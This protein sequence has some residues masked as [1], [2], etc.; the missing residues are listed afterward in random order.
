VNYH[1]IS[2][3]IVSLLQCGVTSFEILLLSPCLEVLSLTIIATLTPD[4]LPIVPV[5]TPGFAIGGT[6]LLASGAVYTLIGIKNK[7]LHIFISAA[8]LA[9][10]GVTVLVLYV[11]NP[12]VSNALRKFPGEQNAF[13]SRS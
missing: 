8:Y 4:Q 5:I 2:R 9:G 12:P 11:M 3:K 13:Y 6:I 10:L 7:W 1:I